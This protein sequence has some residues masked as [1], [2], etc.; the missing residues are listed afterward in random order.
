MFQPEPCNPNND[1]FSSDY[2][3]EP[4]T[5][6]GIP[7]PPSVGSNISEETVGGYI[8][9]Y[10]I[11]AK[12]IG[13]LSETDPEVIDITIAEDGTIT[14]TETGSGWDHFG[15]CTKGKLK[16]EALQLIQSYQQY[17]RGWITFHAQTT[18]Y[19]F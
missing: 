10:I 9:S 7:T 6:S 15:R 1:S 12:E 19:E 18:F 14:D 5:G 2:S 8:E 11:I 3:S 16:G 13:L 17:V 4:P